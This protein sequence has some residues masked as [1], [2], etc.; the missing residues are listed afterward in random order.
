MGKLGD[1][2]T[3]QLNFKFLEFLCGIFLASTMSRFYFQLSKLS[4]V[5]DA[6]VSFPSL[7]FVLF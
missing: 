3:Y 1:T 6:L 7:A 5:N 4:P 2:Q